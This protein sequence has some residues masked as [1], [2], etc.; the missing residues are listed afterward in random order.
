MCV[1]H[2][3]TTELSPMIA[4]VL[5]PSGH[6]SMISMAI[7]QVVIYMAIKVFVPM[8]PRSSTDKHAT[9]IPFWTI[10]AIGSAVIRRHFVISVR[11]RWWLPNAHRNLCWSLGA[12]S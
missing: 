1:M 7:I 5:A 8:K 11:A 12:A 9:R 3:L 4:L 10:V 6:R 2:G